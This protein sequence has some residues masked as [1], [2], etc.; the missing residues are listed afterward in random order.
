MTD[1]NPFEIL[2]AARRSA[3]RRERDSTK[4]GL[5]CADYDRGVAD[6]LRQALS[7]LELIA[8]GLR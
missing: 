7:I 5:A 1:T 6:G 4:K 2:E 3:V 8:A